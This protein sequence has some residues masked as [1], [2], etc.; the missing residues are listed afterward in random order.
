MSTET[1]TIEMAT[2]P[3]ATQIA[4]TVD[5]VE[6]EFVS[7][8]RRAAR[9]LDPSFPQS[10]QLGPTERGQWTDDDQ[11]VTLMQQVEEF[12]D[13]GRGIRTIRLVRTGVPGGPHDGAVRVIA[14]GLANDAALEV[15]WNITISATEVRGKS[16]QLKVDGARKD[17]CIAEFREWFGVTAS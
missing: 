8:V 7:F 16:A 3:R 11:V 4:E 2:G 17:V 9:R 5:V 1:T 12:D 6:P 14:V 15:R 10:G 13:D